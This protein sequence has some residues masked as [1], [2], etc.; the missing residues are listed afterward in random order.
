MKLDEERGEIT[1]IEAANCLIILQ[2]MLIKHGN[3]L[4]IDII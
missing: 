2:N 4:K 3:K 1:L